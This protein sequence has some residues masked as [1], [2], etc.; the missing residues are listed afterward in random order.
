[1]Y[2]ITHYVANLYTLSPV[3]YLRGALCIVKN[4]EAFKMDLVAWYS[5][6][7]LHAYQPIMLYCQ[8]D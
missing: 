3:I 7:S 4:A 8:P 2:I 1:M 5:E 6:Y